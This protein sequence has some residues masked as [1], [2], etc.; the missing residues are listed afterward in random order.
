MGLLG[1][2]WILWFS[3]LMYQKSENIDFAFSCASFSF[4]VLIAIKLEKILSNLEGQ[5]TSGGE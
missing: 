3:F 5:R 2:I 4:L 1:L